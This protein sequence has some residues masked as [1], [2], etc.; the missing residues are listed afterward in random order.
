MKMFHNVNVVRG[1]FAGRVSIASSS[2]P[3]GLLSSNLH[4]G[5]TKGDV[6]G[7]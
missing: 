6:S 1:A 5:D 2:G 7:G 3:V 4:L